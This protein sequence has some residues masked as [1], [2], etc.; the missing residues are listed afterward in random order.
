MYDYELTVDEW[1]QERSD[2]DD[3]F[4]A[5][6]SFINDMLQDCNREKVWDIIWNGLRD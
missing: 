1:K 2:E 3:C 5:S 6:V 4:P